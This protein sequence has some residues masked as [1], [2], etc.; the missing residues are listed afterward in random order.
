M[1]TGNRV[2]SGQRVLLLIGVAGSLAVVGCANDYTCADYK[3]CVPEGGTS[4]AGKTDARVDGHQQHPEGGSDA[5]KDGRG[6][7]GGV[8]DGGSDGTTGTDAADASD[9]HGDT[10]TCDGTQPPR[11]APCVISETFGVFVAPSAS[12]GSDANS[13][14]RVSP[15][16]TI[17]HA[18]ASASGKRVY[19]C[20]ATYAESVSVTS[21]VSVYGGLACPASP[22]SDAGTGGVG[23]WSYVGASALAQVSPSATGFALDVESASGAHFEDMGFTAQDAPAGTPGGSSIA[24][25]VNASTGVSFTRVSATAGKGVTGASPTAVVPG[26]AGDNWCSTTGQAGGPGTASQGGPSGACVC[27]IVAGDS[28]HGGGGG[29]TD[30]VGGAGKA[31]P[32]AAGPG[33]GT[34]APGPASPGASCTV[35]PG[36]LGENGAPSTGGLA[37]AT[38]AL[39]STGWAPASGGAG[40]AGNPGQGGGGGG[41]YDNLGGGGGGA[42]G[43][44]GSGGGGG[45]GGG[46][47]VGIA[48][49]A[50]TVTLSSM[51]LATA[52]GGAGGA[53]AEGEAGQAGG[54]G[55]LESGCIGGSGGKGAGGSGGGGGAGGPSVGIAVTGATPSVT[56]DGASAMPP[57]SSLA[58]PSMFTSGGGGALGGG[59]TPGTA[60][61]GGNA[62]SAGLP[63]SAGSSDAVV[64][65]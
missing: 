17:G 42:G 39:G 46:A 18:I 7:D 48:V 56:I 30:T 22:G 37:G 19:A 11:A 58:S 62:G 36:G 43:C 23:S 38:G 24:V 12:G 1:K 32:S 49:V 13:G 45:G 65:F 6:P 47:S 60:A 40:G 35:A 44:G 41:G 8:G 10:S 31:S 25:M 61:T 28:S 51:T 34:G 27:A 29:S 15:Y 64:A 14:T 57:V 16:L 26:G 21:G 2:L 63:G 33:G 53:G 20:G 3:N 55:G 50:S 54:S 59:G 9:A 4:E 5:T 52:S